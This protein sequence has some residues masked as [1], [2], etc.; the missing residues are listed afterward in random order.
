MSAPRGNLAL[1]KDGRL[2]PA[3]PVDAGTTAL[4][5]PA[6]GRPE[7]GDGGRRGPTRLQLPSIPTLRP[8]SGSRA[9]NSNLSGTRAP[10]RRVPEPRPVDA[11]P[12]GGTAVQHEPGSVPGA[13]P[14]AGEV[15]RLRGEVRPAVR[16]ACGWR[17]GSGRGGRWRLGPVGCGLRP[18]AGRRAGGPGTRGWV[19]GDSAGTQGHLSRRVAVAEDA[20]GGG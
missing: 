8:L 17:L 4:P 20:Q 7:G 10:P 16:A 12:S 2:G 13:R 19:G 6:P 14:A 18:A 15:Q 9:P 3:A 1:T 11:A 5:S